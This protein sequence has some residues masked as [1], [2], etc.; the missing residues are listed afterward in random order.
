MAVPAAALA[1]VP[2]VASV[3][4]AVVV[5]VAVSQAGPKAV[6]AKAAEQY[7]AMAAVSAAVV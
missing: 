3:M 5:M 1:A 2:N 4:A 6:F 7:A